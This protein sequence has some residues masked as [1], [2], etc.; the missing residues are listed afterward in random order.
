MTGMDTTFAGNVIF[1]VLR[2]LNQIT[3]IMGMM[4]DSMRAPLKHLLVDHEGYE[5]KPYLDTEGNITI[6]IGYNLS[7]RGLSDAWINTQY[8]EDVNY[9]YDSLD[10]DYPWFKTLSE[11]RKIALVDM[12]FMGYRKFKGF[13]K[14]LLALNLGDFRLASQEMLASVWALKQKRRSGRLAQIMM[15]GEL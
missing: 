9:F 5:N 3:E 7:A 6:G 1:P 8:D 12:C 15:T 11:A 4:P 14:M 10:N 2:S 13:K